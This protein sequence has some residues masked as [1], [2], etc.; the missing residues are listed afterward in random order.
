MRKADNHAGYEVQGFHDEKGWISISD[1]Y[2]TR[3]EAFLVLCH[4]PV[5]DIEKR[6][7]EALT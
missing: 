5:N 6:V 1:P 3:E 4:M 7:Y 2:E